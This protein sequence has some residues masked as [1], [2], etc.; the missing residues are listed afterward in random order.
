MRKWYTQNVILLDDPTSTGGPWDTTTGVYTTAVAI[1]A[2]VNQA[3]ARE[4]A[5]HGK[6][7]QEVEYKIWADR[8]SEVYAGRRLRWSGDDYV[9]VTKPKDVQQMGHH[10]ECFVRRVW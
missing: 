9:V 1:K 10:I 6:I 4:V 2:A 8:S 5:D 7:G 3:S